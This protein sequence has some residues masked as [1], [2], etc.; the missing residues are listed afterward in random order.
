MQSNSLG[1]VGHGHA[2]NDLGDAAVRRP[3]ADDALARRE[4]R[5]DRQHAIARQISALRLNA[6]AITSTDGCKRNLSEI[7]IDAIRQVER[8]SSR[9]ADWATAAP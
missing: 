2:P 6:L 4:R 7:M 8:V 5:G 1:D 9:S 3:L